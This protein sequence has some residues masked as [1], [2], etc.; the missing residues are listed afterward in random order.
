MKDLLE[1]VYPAPYSPQFNI[2]EGLGNGLSPMSSTTS[3]TTQL[4][5]NR[6]NVKQFMNEI[7]KVLIDFVSFFK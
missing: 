7:M 4:E 3:L 6:K 5:K 1:L 2:V